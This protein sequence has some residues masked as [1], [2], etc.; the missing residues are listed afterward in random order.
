MKIGVLNGDH[1]GHEVAPEAVKVL[2]A[3]AA[4]TGVPTQNSESQRNPGVSP[5]FRVLSRD[6]RA[7][8]VTAATGSSSS[9][10]VG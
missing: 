10:C 1:I 7:L 9:R 3:A 2:P 6:T 8:P 4:A 5:A